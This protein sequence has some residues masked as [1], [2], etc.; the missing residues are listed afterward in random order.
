MHRFTSAA[1]LAAALF[2]AGIAVAA[3][4]PSGAPSGERRFAVH[5]FDAIDLAGPDNVRV[6]TGD[7]VSV[8]ASGDPGALAMLRIDV[9][10]TTLRIGRQPGRSQDRGALVTVTMPAL[11]AATIT[12][13]GDMEAAAG[14]VARFAGRVDGSGTLRLRDLRTGEARIDIA[15]SGDVML[16]GVVR[17]PLAIALPGA[18]D[19]VAIGKAGSVAI[20][21]T[22]TGDVDA[23]GLAT[24]T[25]GVDLSGT[26]NVKARASGTA[27]IAASGTGGVIVAGHPRCTVRHNGLSTV[28]CG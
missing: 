19:L 12:G 15:G 25:L 16:D 24:P 2:A 10:G 17:G 23:A 6:V 3:A 27:R 7:T 4:A 14:P 1:T 20:H 22:G 13:S 8:V 5:R 21:L 11:R 18:G 9:R 26:G 28:R